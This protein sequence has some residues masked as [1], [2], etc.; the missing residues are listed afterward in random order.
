MGIANIILVSIT[1]SSNTALTDADGYFRID[2]VSIGTRNLT[3]AKE[4]YITQKILSVV[5][6][7]DEV[8]LIDNGDPIVVQAVDEKYLF[9][10]G[11]IYYDSGEYTNALTTFQQL[12]IDFPDSQ[13]ADDAQYYIAYINEKKFGYYSKALLEYYELITNYPDSI[14][15]DDAQLGM[16]N[17]YFANG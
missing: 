6:K 7:E 16:G 1:A 2:E 13:Y 12:I 4:N 5:I 10:G 9:D 17:C 14:W 15:I 3:I 11:I 8:T